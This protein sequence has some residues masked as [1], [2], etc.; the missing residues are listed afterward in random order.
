MREG[1]WPNVE[2]CLHTSM[3]F[4]WKNRLCETNVRMMWIFKLSFYKKALQS[5]IFNIPGLSFF[6]AFRLVIN[7]NYDGTHVYI[8][9]S[10][11]K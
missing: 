1:R 8:L 11:V 7:I 6:L 4:A 5:G 2:Q 9:V 10:G 3:C